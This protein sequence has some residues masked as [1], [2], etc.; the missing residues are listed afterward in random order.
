MQMDWIAR[1]EATITKTKG[2][3]LIGCP[4]FFLSSQVSFNLIQPEQF[5]YFLILLRYIY[6]LSSIF[7]NFHVDFD[8]LT[9]ISANHYISVIDP[10]SSTI[11]Q[12]CISVGSK[13]LI[14][15]FHDF[16]RN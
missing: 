9:V 13:Q 16:Q 12:S 7:S 5:I 11:I 15:P 1:G 4:V 6:T 2:C 10:K 8:F 3:P 14:S